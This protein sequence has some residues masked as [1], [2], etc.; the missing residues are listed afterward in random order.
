MKFLLTHV[1]TNLDRLT[2]DGMDTFQAALETWKREKL[3][4]G[5]PVSGATKKT[6]YYWAKEVSHLALKARKS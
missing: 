3:K 6:I 2:V 1:K 4:P 5:K